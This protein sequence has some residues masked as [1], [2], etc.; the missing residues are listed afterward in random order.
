[1]EA[2]AAPT[3]RIEL[4]HAFNLRD[5]GGYGTAS[6]GTTK[7]RRVY[8]ADGV[9]RLTPGDAVRLRE[10]LGVTMVMDLRTADERDSGGVYECE[11]VTT[12]H[13]PV[14]RKTWEGL[15]L[16]EA[17]SPADFLTRR[18]L[19][20]TE[21]GAG[22]IGAAMEIISS[23]GGRPVLFHCSAGKDRTGVVAALLLELLGVGDDDI[24]ADYA[25][26]AEAMD[27][28]VTWIKE[29]RPEAMD[30]MNAQPAAFLAAPD[31]AMHS[32][33]AEMRNRHGSIPVY[34]RTIGVSRAALDSL[35]SDLVDAG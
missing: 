14:L 3:R 33:L 35:Q 34:L 4:G 20:M 31:A 11:G 7:W 21:Q 28:L 19:E 16:D 1:M 17:A 29:H 9:H 32:F 5:I 8:R 26:S 25:M 30:A 23:N 13:L 15:D 10:E 24:A 12:V 27:R 18:Y 22:A 6:G 2:I